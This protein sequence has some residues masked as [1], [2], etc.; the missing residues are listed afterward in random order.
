MKSKIKNYFSNNPRSILSLF[1][2]L[3]LGYGIVYFTGNASSPEDPF[4]YQLTTTLATVTILYVGIG[5]LLT[6]LTK[7]SATLA[8]S[9]HSGI[10]IFKQALA[11]VFSC[12]A[13]IWLLGEYG[14]DAKE[15]VILNQEQAAIYSL[16]FFVL[17]AITS[18]SSF[19]CSFSNVHKVTHHTTSTVNEGPE[20]IKETSVNTQKPLE[21][22]PAQ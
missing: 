7:E 5:A 11:R 16:C 14:D 4:V 3:C 8:L 10:S 17:L 21:S 9:I 19:I 1:Y 18:F 22:N 13:A 2:S 6:F 20:K 12:S 15:W